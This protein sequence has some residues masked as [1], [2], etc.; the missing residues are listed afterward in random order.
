M[1]L[2]TDA[3][4]I[5]IFSRDEHKQHEMRLR[6]TD[7][8]LRWFIGDV[9]DVARLRRAMAGIGCVIHAA[10]LKHVASGEYNPFEAVQTNV[11]GTQHVAEAAI[12][13]GVARCVLISTDK[14]VNPTNLYGATKLCA[15]R[16]FMAAGS[17]A[18]G[19]ERLFCVLRCGNLA[20][21][22]G[23]VIPTWR[24]LIRAG[25]QFVPVTDMR[26]TRYWLTE[27]EAERALGDAISG[28]EAL[29][30][31]RMRAYRVADLAQAFGMPV[32]VVGLRAG[33]KLHEELGN[34]E[35]SE[36]AQKL[37]VGELREFLDHCQAEELTRAGG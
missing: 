9:R 18:G 8:R 12:D 23:S 25:A 27:R 32:H 20:A 5:C 7:K 4:R 21:S 31:P 24:A 10:A 14:A 22:R 30:E 17:Y 16:I 19:R 1:L 36:Q 33:E 13:C 29:Y 2:R 28:R 37:S 35:T 6:Y 34:G 3:E 11:I 15:E 26:A